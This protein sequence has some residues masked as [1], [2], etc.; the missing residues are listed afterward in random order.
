MAYLTILVAPPSGRESATKESPLKET[1][2][3]LGRN[4]SKNTTAITVWD[5]APH[6]EIA[7][8]AKTRGITSIIIVTMGV[9]CRPLE[10]DLCDCPLYIMLNPEF[11]IPRSYNITH[12]HRNNQSVHMF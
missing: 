6:I 7:G 12:H 8:H 2:A 1:L 4:E 5:M 9:A 10:S 3:G 11:R